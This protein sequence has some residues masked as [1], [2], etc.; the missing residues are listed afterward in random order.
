M[1]SLL[2]NY[3]SAS[4]DSHAS[5]TWEASFMTSVSPSRSFTLPRGMITL[6]PRFIIIIRSLP[7]KPAEKPVRAKEHTDKDESEKN[8]HAELV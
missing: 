1:C 8:R 4:L 6:S 7:S 5:F 3:I 2:F